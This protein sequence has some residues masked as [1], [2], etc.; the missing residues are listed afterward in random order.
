MSEEGI[1]FLKK[2]KVFSL[3][4]LGSIPAAQLEGSEFDSCDSAI[5]L[6]L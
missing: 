6:N 5:L 3:E 1:A 2:S 4:Q